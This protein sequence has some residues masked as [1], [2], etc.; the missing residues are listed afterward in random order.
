MET[1]HLFFRCN[2]AQGIIFFPHLPKAFVITNCWFGL[3]WLS[4]LQFMF[5]T[6][7]ALP[8]LE[9]HP[10][11][12]V[13][14]RCCLSSYVMFFYSFYPKLLL[15][16]FAMPILHILSNCI[17]IFA[18]PNCNLISQLEK[19]EGGIKVH[20]DHGEVI[21]AD[22][23]LVATGNFFIMYIVSTQLRNWSQVT[24]SIGLGNL[25]VFGCP[26]IFSLILLS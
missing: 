25:S 7:K 13:K 21:L 6:S 12:K 10:H 23:V 2:S 1:E 24:K 19:A 5:K 3:V 4:I 14:S 17:Y 20:T 15:I 8:I 18:T 26:S 9:L 11:P 22:V 16:I